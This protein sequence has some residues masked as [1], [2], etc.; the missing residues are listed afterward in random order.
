MAEAARSDQWA[1]RDEAC[2][3]SEDRTRPEELRSRG[4]EF[5]QQ[6]VG[7]SLDLFVPPLGGAVHARDQAA[8]VEAAEVT[9]RL[10]L[11]SFR[12]WATPRLLTV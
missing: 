9:Y 8:S 7:D 6:S 12:A 10:A 3:T 5:L 1:N 4:V 11:M 2:R